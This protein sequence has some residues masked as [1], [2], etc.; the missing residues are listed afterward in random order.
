M[1]QSSSEDAYNIELTDE[2][3]LGEG[4]FGQV[5]KIERK[6]DGLM[7]AAKF[8]KIPLNLMNNNDHLGVKRESNILKQAEHPFII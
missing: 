3:L 1:E 6:I 8:F 7:C 2:N 5:Y 4:S